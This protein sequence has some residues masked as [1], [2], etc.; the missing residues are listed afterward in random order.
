MLVNSWL[1]SVLSVHTKYTF[2]ASGSQQNLC[3]LPLAIVRVAI[4][5]GGERGDQLDLATKS[6]TQWVRRLWGDYTSQQ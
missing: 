5:P 4:W 6:S 2:K 1:L 3:Q